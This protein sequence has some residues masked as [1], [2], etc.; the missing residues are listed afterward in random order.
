MPTTTNAIHV[1][2]HGILS[3]GTVTYAAG[4]AQILMSVYPY[5]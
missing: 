5:N 4:D 1:N 2:L 3:A